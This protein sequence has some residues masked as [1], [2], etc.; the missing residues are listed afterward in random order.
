ML[1]HPTEMDIQLVQVLQQGAKGRALGHLSKGID[2]LGEALAA[3]TELAVRTGDIG[4]G[5]VDVAGEEDAGVYLAPVCT[6]L[7]AV[8]TTSVKIGYLISTKHVVHILGEL[9]LQGGHD[10][11]LLANKNLC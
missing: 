9:S 8:L 7:F 2:I 6:H 10:G 1:L 5:V 3:I 11:K 4:V